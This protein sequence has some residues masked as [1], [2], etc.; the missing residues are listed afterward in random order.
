MT[1]VDQLEQVWLRLDGTQRDLVLGQLAEQG[2][3]TSETAVTAGQA[4]MLFLEQVRPG[5]PGYR[6]AAVMRARGALDETALRRSLDILVARHQVLRSS[7]NHAGGQMRQVVQRFATARLDV[8]DLTGAGPGEVDSFVDDLLARPLAVDAPPLWRM[9]LV[10]VAQDEALVVLSLHHLICD[11][12]SIGLLVAEVGEAYRALVRGEEPVLAPLPIQY[13]D[14]AAWLQ[15]RQADSRPDDPTRRWWADHLAGMP[16]ALT[17]PTDLPRPAVQGFGGAAEPFTLPD[18]TMDAVARCAQQ[19]GVTVFMVLLAAYQVLLSRFSGQHQ[20]VVGVPDAGRHRAEVEPLIGFFVNMLPIAADLG[21]APTF[22]ELLAQTSGACRG[23]YGHAE[24]PFEAMVEDAGLARDLSRSPLFQAAFSYQAEPS[25]RVD[26]GGDLVLERVPR[27]A[28]GARF[29]V[30]VQAFATPQGLSGWFEYD[31]ALFLPATME[32]LT[33]AFERLVAGVV[34]DPARPVD[35]H[36][37]LDPEE[38]ARVVSLATGPTTTWPGAGFLP[39]LLDR[40]AS[41]QP[42]APALRDADRQLDQAGLAALRHRLAHLLL[43]RGLGRGAIIAVALERS[44]ELVASLQGVMAA[45]AAYLPIDL[46][47]PAERLAAVLARA[48]LVITSREVAGTLGLE[49]V[50]PCPLWAWEDGVAELEA[51]ADHPPAVAIGGDDIAYVIYTSGSTG[52]PKGVANTHAGLRNRLLWMQDAYGLGPGDRVL[53]KTPYTFDVSVWEFFWPT[54][55]AA[56][57]VVLPPGEHRDPTQVARAVRDDDI[58]VLHFVPSMLRLFL[59]QPPA[60]EAR[61]L[62][63]VVCSGEALPRDLVDQFHT[64]YPGGRV[65]LENLYGPTEAAIDVTAWACPAGET[66]PVPIGRPIANTSVH[67][68]DPHRVP[69]PVGVIGELYIGGDNV[70]AGYI[71]REDLTRERFVPDP[72]APGGRLYRTGDL[73]RLVDDGSPTG[74]LEYLGRADRQV[75]LRGQRIE[76]GEIEDVLCRHPEVAAAVVSARTFG[77]G[78]VRLVG[79]VQPVEPGADVDGVALAGHLRRTLPEY[80]VPGLWMAVTE[81]PLSANGKCDESRLPQPDV[82]PVA[83]TIVAPRD[84]VER[85]ITGVWAEVLGVEQVGVDDAFFD[86]GGHSLLLIQVREKLAAAL[87]RELSMVELFQH[88]TPA[89]LAAHLRGASTTTA[90]SDGRSRADLRLRAHAG[91]RRAAARRSHHQEG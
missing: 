46:G 86:L 36:A 31:P 10:R 60:A 17:L 75:K 16:S 64:T 8:H 3:A 23:A 43:R 65:A 4:S 20:V 50:A 72:F 62:R 48:D 58:T 30:E 59:P 26:L 89:T 28:S 44:L 25:A 11:G 49:A 9:H 67:V 12:W 2:L 85:L 34:A 41:E 32:R 6:V 63:L 1:V 27:P 14:Y 68:L 56:E 47:A 57:L 88:P 82:P 71:G 83:R 69:V 61:R 45:G 51:C 90:A 70:A 84:E 5:N 38:E 77:P 42:G 78:D 22:S 74:Y 80:M 24:V 29:D 19:H 55:A 13:G 18:T 79:Y 81:F 87:D 33:R 39:E 40:S 52:Q 21:G 54:L 15:E 7:F 53:Q 66:G 73:G 37:L 91:Q 76:L 35:R